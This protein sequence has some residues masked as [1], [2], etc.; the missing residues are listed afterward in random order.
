MPII[1][2]PGTPIAKAVSI[3]RMNSPNTREGFLFTSD[4]NSKKLELNLLN[5][6]GEELIISLYN[7][8]GKL[9]YT[10]NQKAGSLQLHN[11][12]FLE[13]GVYL[14]QIATFQLSNNPIKITPRFTLM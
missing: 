14:T 8:Q 13:A 10:W 7:L 3:G 12:N 1:I 4:A 9:M 5:Y 11:L 2:M 6:S